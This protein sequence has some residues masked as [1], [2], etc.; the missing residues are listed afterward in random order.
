[1]KPLGATLSI[2]VWTALCAS[3]ASPAA[4]AV[5]F[6]DFERHS[7]GPNWT[8]LAG[9]GSLGLVAMSDLGLVTG[10]ARGGAV[11]WAADTFLADQFS[12]ALISPARADSML[13]QVFVRLRT[14]DNARY[15]FHWSNYFGGR[16]EIKYDGVPTPQTRI[17]ASLSAPEPQPGDRIRIE[18]RGST[19]SAYHNGVLILTA[20]DTEPQA[21]T[22][23]GPLGMVFR[24]TTEVPATYPQ[25]VV[26]E[27]SGGDLA[28][29]SVEAEY[30]GAAPLVRI[31]P[32]PVARSANVILAA[33]V[34]QHPDLSF[35]LHDA[36]GRLV[37]AQH[38]DDPQD[39]TLDV[40]RISPGVHFYSVVAAGVPLSTGSLVIQR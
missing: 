39:F 17:L 20:D 22:G 13:L 12:E 36:R 26:E 10:P 38:I 34:R 3:A 30:D 40:G 11:A 33:G 18:A 5:A 9:S 23:A 24:F 32:N 1:M 6:D 19:I 7:L 29:T 31:F 25:S 27:W 15:G 16:W 35:R 2:A 8:V 14:S 21:I 37:L 4:G 28:A